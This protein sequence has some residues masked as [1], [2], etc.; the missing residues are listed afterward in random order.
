MSDA[1]PS[2][3]RSERPGLDQEIASAMRFLIDAADNPKPYYYNV[4]EDFLTPAIFFPQPEITSR[5]DTLKTYALEFSMFVK[6][7]DK[8]TQ[9]AHQRAFAALSALQYRHCVVPLIDKDGALTGRGF[10]LNDPSMRSVDDGAVHLTIMWDSARPY[11]EPK[12]IKMVTYHT[13]MWVKSAYEGAV[14][15]IG[16]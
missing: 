6:F 12:A 7:F 14:D 9:S 2:S 16:G 8:D 13:N 10:R 15:Q 11:F 5:G 4:P 1:Y 3:P